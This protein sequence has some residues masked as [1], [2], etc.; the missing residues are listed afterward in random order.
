MKTNKT[1]QELNLLDRFLFAEAVEDREF[2]QIVLDII[3]DGDVNLKYPPQT[4]KEIRSG[5]GNKKIRFDVWDMD[6]NNTVYDTE[7]QKTNTGNLPKRSR[8]Y[9]GVMDSKLLKEGTINYNDLNDVYII[10]IAPF[11]LFGK[12]RYKY[13]FS[14]ICEEDTD[15]RLKDGAVRMFLNTRGTDRDGVS[16][17][18]I[19]ML[20]YFE[21]TTEEVAKASGSERIYTLHKKVETIRNNEETGVKYMNEMEEKLL[22]RQ[23][24]LEAGLKAGRREGIERVQHIALK[25]LEAQMDK[26]VVCDITGLTMDE[27]VK[28]EKTPQTETLKSK[29]KTEYAAPKWRNRDI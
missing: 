19:A 24:G 13:T 17:E 28:I 21:E 23:A 26:Q 2:L 15:I 29:Q 4:E 8:Y 9:Q 22:E 20:K 7:V 10:L 14:M 12:G 1:L 27:L 16:E 6:E 3:F 25:M 11:D 5:T 18:L